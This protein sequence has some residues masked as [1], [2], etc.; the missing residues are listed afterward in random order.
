MPLAQ[1]RIDHQGR[2]ASSGKARRHH[3]LKEVLSSR[4]SELSLGTGQ[5]STSFF[6]RYCVITAVTDFL[7]LIAAKN[8]LLMIDQPSTV[9]DGKK[10]RWFKSGAGRRGGTW[11]SILGARK[12]PRS[13]DC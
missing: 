7:G 2:Q 5:V 8:W 3:R 12:Q 1:R 13:S 9:F 4:G 10:R 11:A 6:E